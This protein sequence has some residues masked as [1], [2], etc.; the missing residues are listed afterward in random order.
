MVQNTPTPSRYKLTLAYDGTHYVGWQVQDNGTSIQTLV[1][2]ALI[3][4]L[5]HPLDLTG[6]G[7]TDA[8]VHAR[9]QIAHFDT[10]VPLQPKKLLHSLNSLLPPDVRALSLDPAAPTFHARYSAA[11]KIYHYHL[12]L[13]PIADPFLAPY[14]LHLVDRLDLAKLREGASLF[15]GTHDFTSF[16]NDAHRGSAAHD[17]IRTLVRLDV[18]EQQGGIRLEF[19]G[20]GFLYKMVR[21][22]VGTLIEYGKGK[23]TSADIDRIFTAK[24]RRK[25]GPAAPPQGLFLMQ[26]LY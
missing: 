1:Q 15:L 24:D 4:A 16:A 23:L 5:R 7:R 17:P 18:I 21:N 6:S 25:A 9:G 26:V 2:Q 22:I 14:R 11:G 8:G 3:T 10:P 20:N 12:H 13:D 19:E